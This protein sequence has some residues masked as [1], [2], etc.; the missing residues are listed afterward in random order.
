MD[1]TLIAL[2]DKFIEPVRNQYHTLD[3]KL[4]RVL[5]I[6]E[7]VAAQERETS[8]LDGRVIR[9]ENEQGLHKTTLDTLRGRNQ[10]ILWLMGIVGAPILVLLSAAGISNIMHLKLL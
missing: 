2:V 10:V 3:S 7:R 4:D 9:V 8:N 1:D 5:A 6:G